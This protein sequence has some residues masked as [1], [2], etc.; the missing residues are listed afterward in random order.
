METP[1]RDLLLVEDNPIFI[2]HVR[3]SLEASSTWTVTS[4]ETLAAAAAALDEQ[5]FEAVVVDLGLP[6]SEGTDTFTAMRELVDEVP[7]IVMTNHEQAY[8]GRA[9]VRAGAAD[10]LTKREVT[11][12]ALEWSLDAAVERADFRRDLQ[13]HRIHRAIEVERRR[14]GR[15]LHD[16]VIQRL[17]AAGLELERCLGTP[18]GVA[19]AADT[20]SMRAV[21][22]TIDAAVGDLRFAID[23]MHP[24]AEPRSLGDEFDTV[25]REIQHG[26][27]RPIHLRIL[28]N[29]EQLDP[30]EGQA[31]LSVF[32]EGIM[33]AV[34]HGI[35]P[36]EAEVSADQTARIEIRA[37]VGDGP[38]TPGGG[39]G[40]IGMAERATELG[41]HSAFDVE[42]AVST[43]TWEVPCRPR[44]P[45]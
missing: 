40:L 43:L 7:I 5:P 22:G 1:Q 17:F 36:V 28:G 23:R 14:I 45:A 2:A 4:V 37:A 39:R 13:Q 41:G 44:Q 8:L 30:V 10:F 34:R 32:R 27:G 15:D 16:R 20:R 31:M 9:L 33:N 6:D 12:E 24:T 21:L 25:S 38:T 18:D 11:P 26:T 19:D 35:G 29:V 3:R 42:D